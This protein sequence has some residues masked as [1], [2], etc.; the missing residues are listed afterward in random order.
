MG[1]VRVGGRVVPVH[2]GWGT[3][4]VKMGER[5]AQMVVTKRRV[6]EGVE[7]GRRWKSSGTRKALSKVEMEWGMG[8]GLSRRSLVRSDC[9]WGRRT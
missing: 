2:I 1:R 5:R 6:G 8:E 9:T 4:G 3:G 7:M